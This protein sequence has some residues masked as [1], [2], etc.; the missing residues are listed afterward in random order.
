MNRGSVA[1]GQ[2]RQPCAPVP[3][4]PVREAAL[5]FVRW[6]G[7]LSSPPGKNVTGVRMGRGKVGALGTLAR[8]SWPVALAAGIAG[9][10]LLRHGL[11][12]WF[13]DGGDAFGQLFAHGNP[14]APLAWLVLAACALASL[15][16]FAA[17]RRRRTLLD[18]QTGLDSVAALGWRDF[19]RLVG[20]AFRRQG[21]VVEESG[22]GGA[23]GGIDLVLRKDDRRTLVQ[24]KQWR[25]RKVPV[26]VVREMMGLLV[27]HRAHA[28]RIAALGGFTRDAARFAAGKPI[29]L[30]DGDTLLAMIRGVQATPPG[31]TRVAPGGAPG[32][33]ASAPAADRARAAA[34][35]AAS[36]A[37]D[38][39]AP[40]DPPALAAETTPDCPRCGE[41]MVSRINRFTAATFWGCASFPAC[42]GTR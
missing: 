17:A 30:I 36:A 33:P 29:A 22:L 20:E 18:A 38:D 2:P 28:V 1:R 19:E 26:N 16:S 13:A 15:A 31:A 11:P 12:A 21:Y 7:A 40:D 6:A 24:C 25:R 41:A 8:L 42:R 37:Q 23:D 32:T 34:T 3:G 14:F 5:S 27:H 9:F 39:A 4:L 10:A 35:T